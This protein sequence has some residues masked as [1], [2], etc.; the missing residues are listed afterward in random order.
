MKPTNELSG[1]APPFPVGNRPGRRSRWVPLVG[2]GA[3]VLAAV[4]FASFR[5]TPS[6]PP[7]IDVARVPAATAQLPAT[8]VP[9]P[10]APEEVQ[11]LAEAEPGSESEGEAV[12]ETQAPAPGQVMRLP[13]VYINVSLGARKAPDEAPASAVET[14]H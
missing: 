2:L 5:P 8:A 7:L 10:A 13:P 11:A 3:V 9:V 6:T 12:A 4:I 1:Q 14:G